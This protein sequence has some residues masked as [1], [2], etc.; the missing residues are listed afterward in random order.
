[1]NASRS[2]ETVRGSLVA[3]GGGRQGSGLLISSPVI[4]KG[5]QL[6][7]RVF[8]DKSFE[9]VKR[10]SLRNYFLMLEDFFLHCV[11]KGFDMKEIRASTQMDIQI[12]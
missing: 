7:H 2:A 6:S 10:K 4:Q 11:N 8:F 9:P 3:D 5:R 12:C 1:M